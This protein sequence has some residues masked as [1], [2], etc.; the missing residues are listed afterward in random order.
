MTARRGAN[1]G[2]KMRTGKEGEGA[3]SRWIQIIHILLGVL[4]TAA[5]VIGSRA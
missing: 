5:I 3:A 4:A 1:P 2:A